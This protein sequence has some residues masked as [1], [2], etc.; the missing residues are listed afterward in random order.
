MGGDKRTVS[1]TAAGSHASAFSCTSPTLSS[2]SNNT[3]KYL[4]QNCAKFRL[5]PVKSLKIRWLT[6]IQAA[7]S[8]LLPVLLHT[9]LLRSTEKENRFPEA[10]VRRIYPWQAISR[11]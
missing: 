9:G 8:P 7:A 11:H 5:A 6:I 2:S 4:D 1:V 3:L 10:C